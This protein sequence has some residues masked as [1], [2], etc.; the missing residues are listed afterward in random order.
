M[1]A[2]PIKSIDLSSTEDSVIFST[3]NSQLFKMIINLERPTDEIE[4]DYLVHAFHSRPINGMD[5]CIKKPFIAT[6]SSD[7]TVKVWSYRASG[8][9]SLSGFSLEVDQSFQEE[10]NSVAFHPSGFH[11]V[12][13]FSDRIR[14][15][16]LFEKSLTSYKDLPIKA[17]SEI[18][19]SNGGHLFAC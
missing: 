15:M 6:C 1:T 5:V 19:F 8:G 11:L 17:C 7:R 13:G 3:D 10:A 9:S 4:Y 18:V 14:M 2:G 16:N 12:V